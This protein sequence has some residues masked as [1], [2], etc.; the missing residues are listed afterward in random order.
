MNQNNENQKLPWVPFALPKWTEVKDRDDVSQE[1]KD[2]T[3]RTEILDNIDKA[4][5]NKV[6]GFI[7]Q[8]TKYYIKDIDDFKKLY[9]RTDLRKGKILPGP[10]LFCF[11]VIVAL[12]TNHRYYLD[13]LTERGGAEYIDYIKRKVNI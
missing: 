7:V 5:K 4:F 8:M 13:R 3:F 6:F 1:Y 12:L 10:Q 9:D 11:E 2:S